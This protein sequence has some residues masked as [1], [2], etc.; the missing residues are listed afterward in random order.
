MTDLLHDEVETGANLM[1]RPRLDNPRFTLV[2]PRTESMRS[3]AVSM[4]GAEH[5]GLGSIAAYLRSRGVS[6]T[7]LNYQLST[8]FNAWDGL[9]DPRQSYSTEALAAEIL[10]TRPN[11]VGFCVTSMTLMASI[12]ICKIIRKERPNTVLGLGGPHAILCAAELMRHFPVIDF[13]GMKDGERAMALLCDAL[14]RGVFPCAIPEMITRAPKTIDRQIVETYRAMPKG[15]DDLPVPAR[16]DLIWMLL[17]API[18]E[19]RITTSRG[20]NYDCTFCIDAMR[21]DRN[22]YAR[23]AAQTA[24]EIEMLNRML[25]VSHFWMSDDNFVTGAPSSRQR[26]RAIADELLARGLDVTYRVRFRS[27]TFVK[28]PEL[29][30]RLAESGLVSAFVGLEAGSEE[31]LERFKKRTT[32]EQH[33]IMITQMRELGIALQ[34][35]FIM[36]EPYCSFADLEASAKFLHEI[37]EMYLES[38]FT[39]SLDVFPGT[40]IAVDMQRDGLLHPGFN[41]TSPYDAYDFRDPNL[42]KFAKLIEVSHDQDTIARD[43]WLYRYRTNLLPRAYRKLLRGGVDVSAWKRREE[44]VISELNDANM[45]FFMRGLDEARRGEAGRRFNEF[46]DTAFVVQEAAE[47]RLAALYQEVSS[48]VAALSAKPRPAAPAPR[49]IEEL[50]AHGRQKIE[51]ALGALAAHGPLSVTVLGGGT[52]NDVVLLRGAARSFIFRSRRERDA[53]HIVAYLARL[54]GSASMEELGGSFRLRSLEQE[55]EFMNQ[56]R[57]AG[58]RVPAVV[59]KGDGWVVLD[60][61][62]GRAMA[63]ALQDG[64]DPGLVLRMLHELKSA[65]RSGLVLGDRWGNNEIVDRAGH[66][67]FIDFDVEWIPYQQSHALNE[68]DIAVALFGALLHSSRRGDLLDALREYGMPLLYQWGY[69]RERIATVLRGYRAFYLAADKPTCELSLDAGQYGELAAPLDRLIDIFQNASPLVHTVG[70]V[71]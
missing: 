25:G 35:G 33:K 54:Y 44:A 66:L 11:V 49:S 12:D 37:G 64:A 16:D 47:A 60:Y 42:G 3:S 22:W 61:I 53:G 18:T 48:A 4:A 51:Q 57:A 36:F 15:V 5:L 46:R 24:D 52:L 9:V 70:C 23:S 29:L 32:V 43:K 10:A 38:N 13:I 6:V 28:E 40:E 2:L 45:V 34:C 62:E 1:P 65:H 50:S 39:H 55:L 31:Q 58:L 17:R 19:S 68:M 41:A 59:A 7:Q 8:F 14:R 21:Y 20:C 30:S 26:A 27:D 71:E 63:D 56:A 69:S 67:H